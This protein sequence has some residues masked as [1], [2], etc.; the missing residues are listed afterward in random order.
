MF[1]RKGRKRGA[2]L[3]GKVEPVV[4][5]RNLNLSQVNLVAPC[6]VEEDFLL[7]D[8]DTYM[9]DY[10]D[11]K[12]A[13]T[14]EKYALG[15]GK[16]EI[17]NKDLVYNHFLRFGRH[18]GRIAY[19]IKENGEKV[20]FTNFY[21]EDYIKV[22]EDAYNKGVNNEINGTL[23]Y[24]K[25]EVKPKRIIVNEGAKVFPDAFRNNEF[26]KMLKR[27][28]ANFDTWKYK[29][30]H[31]KNG[32]AKELFIDYISNHFEPLMEPIAKPKVC[33]IY[34]YYEQKN[35]T[36]NQTNLAFFIKYG[37]DQSRWRN[38]D[39]TILFIINGY[40]CEVLIPEMNNI[41]VLKQDNCSDVECWN[42][43]ITYFETK[44]NK[45]ISKSFMHICLLN[46]N[47]FGP[48]YND[49]INH[50]WLDNIICQNTK[51]S[52]N[53]KK[54]GEPFI[55]NNKIFG[56]IDKQFLMKKLNYKN[57]DI[58]IFEYNDIFNKNYNKCVIYS[59]YDK[60]NIIKIY[61]IE[62]LIMLSKLGY[63]V[64]FYSSCTKITNY[65]ENDLPFKINYYP[66]SKLKS[67]GMDWYMWLDGC[68]QIKQTNYNYDWIMLLND[69]MVL[70]IN[71]FDNMKNTIEYMENSSIDFWGHWDS[72]EI[73]YHIMS[74]LYE[75]K[76]KIIDYYIN[77]C[78]KN[79]LPCKTKAEVVVKCET[80]FTLYI[81]QMGFNTKAVINKDLYNFQPP[82]IFRYNEDN[83][84]NCPSH[85][86]LNISSWI[87]KPIAFGLKYK[88]IL[89]YLKESNI[90]DECKE[91]LRYIHIGKY[92]GFEWH[93]GLIPIDLY[94]DNN[95]FGNE[96]SIF[97]VINF[98]QKYV[99]YHD[100][101]QFL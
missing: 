51:I 69:S 2:I 39:V 42:N 78:N 101:I 48:I 32:S 98:K 30:V 54:Y 14:K 91:R 64:L 6:L 93:F 77:F 67:G 17:I 13:Y 44:Y 34:V 52:K 25:N 90:N 49:N 8:V 46:C 35:E 3:N 10:P 95:I 7:F 24:K 97:N 55:I 29:K 19:G 21:H 16:R 66:N 74:S 18:E 56:N 61:V 71:G 75:F 4:L 50:H 12:D 100:N 82:K 15:Q 99:K 37:L 45:H 80:N 87:N 43:G 40:Q 26:I 11:V 53:T 79:L 38:M 83:V 70:G 92:R 20:R 60:D 94:R 63:N 47:Q 72:N 62:S 68:K 81:K 85:N 5:D 22:C 31:G 86:P 96:I 88:Y 57:S 89:A 33:I 58:N 41:H 23:H 65:D 73:N 9:Q 84:I 28:W 76:Y 59:H 27:E 36:K 1:V